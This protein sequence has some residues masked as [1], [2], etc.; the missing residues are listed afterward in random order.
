MADTVLING[1]PYEV[2]E[3]SF[4]DCDVDGE[5]AERWTLYATPVPDLCAALKRSLER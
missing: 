1:R 3:W 4:N 5:G 2:V